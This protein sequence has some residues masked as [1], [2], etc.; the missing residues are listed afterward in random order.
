MLNSVSY[1]ISRGVSSTTLKAYNSAWS[2]FTAFCLAFQI[3]LFP[4]LVSTVCAFLIHN[5]QSRNLKICTIRK[6]LAGIQFHARLHDPDY[7]SLFS[8]PSIR[9]LLKGISKD[10]QKAVDKRLPIT[11]SVLKKLIDILRNGLFSAYINK[12]LEAVFLTAFY[13]FMRPGE[14]TT[15]SQS[16]DPARDLTLSDVSF[17]P[18]HF[19]VFLKHSKTDVSGKGVSITISKS[20]CNYCPFTSMVRYLKVRPTRHKFSPLFMLPNG[21]PITKEW[22]R[23][24]LSAV[25]ERCGL[26]SRLYTGH[27]FRIGAATSAA[28]CGI[29][30]SSIKL[31]GRWSSRA[32]ESYIRPDSKTILDAQQVFSSSIKVIL[33]NYWWW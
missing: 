29:P 23:I 3:T 4:I 1:Y 27:S 22:F 5:Y 28:G 2:L 20:N 18:C 25:S 15:G 19:T 24:H 13:G 6:L 10:T 33:C 26:S 16:F 12:L 11:I 32:F 17:S 14:F 21:F 9:L 30:T 31:L 8:T 7:P